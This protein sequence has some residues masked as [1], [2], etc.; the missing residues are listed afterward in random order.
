MATDSPWDLPVWIRA[1]LRTE[2]NW[3]EL[4]AR[5]KL[6]DGDPDLVETWYSVSLGLCPELCGHSD[7]MHLRSD[8]F[9]QA[10]TAGHLT[11]SHCALVRSKAQPMLS[12]RTHVHCSSMHGIHTATMALWPH[13]LSS[14]DRDMQWVQNPQP[15]CVCRSSPAG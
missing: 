9:R 4:E 12:T 6:E 11:S 2:E 15:M 1:V 10:S 3:A 13:Y 7:C 14:S 8:D 5:A